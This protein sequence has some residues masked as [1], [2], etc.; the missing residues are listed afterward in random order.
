MTR[1]PTLLHVPL[2]RASLTTKASKVASTDTIH[3]IS[4]PSQTIYIWRLCKGMLHAMG[5]D[6]KHCFTV[7]LGPTFSYTLGCMIFLEYMGFV[8]AVFPL[9]YG[10]IIE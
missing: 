7:Q 1:P 2:L 9:K 8:P 5:T 6:H 10:S 4:V 3:I